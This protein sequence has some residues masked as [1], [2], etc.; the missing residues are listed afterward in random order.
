M[1]LILVR[2]KCFSF[3]FMIRHMFPTTLGRFAIGIVRYSWSCLLLSFDF[4]SDINLCYET[5]ENLTFINM[6][7]A[8]S[9]KFIKFLVVCVA[10]CRLESII[11]A[12]LKCINYKCK[13]EK[14]K[15]IYKVLVNYFV[16][17]FVQ[18]LD[19]FRFSTNEAFQKC[20]CT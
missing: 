2:R 7:R 10:Q 9:N 13:N 6:Y 8:N 1:N 15:T 4:L 17:G 16:H 12:L 18:H 14:N 19:R 5:F 11:M 3:C 20:F